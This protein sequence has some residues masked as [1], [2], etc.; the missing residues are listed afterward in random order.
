MSLLEQE[1]TRKR[2]VDK[3]ITQL[4]LGMGNKEEDEVTRIWDSMIYTREKEDQL[5]KLYYLILYKEYPK[6]ENTWEPTLVI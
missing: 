2:W 3:N 5:P 6:A 4:E 1:N